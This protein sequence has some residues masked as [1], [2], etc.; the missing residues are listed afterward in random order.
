M[1]YNKLTALL[2]YIDLFQSQWHHIPN[3]WQGAAYPLPFY[4]CKL[5]WFILSIA[6][7][8]N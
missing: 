3:I 1:K 5:L 7:T 6:I 2:G 4:V 8:A